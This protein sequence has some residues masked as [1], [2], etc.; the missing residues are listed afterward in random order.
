VVDHQ[1]SLFSMEKPPRSH[2]NIA[3]SMRLNT[4]AKITVWGKR[5]E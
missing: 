4:M 2:P 3:R 1:D 5:S